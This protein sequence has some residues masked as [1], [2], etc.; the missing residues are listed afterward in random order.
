MSKLLFVGCGKMG[1][2]F[3]RGTVQ[4]ADQIVVIDPAPFPDNIRV[5]ENV[6]WIS[7]FDKIDPLYRP[8]VIVLAIK[9]QHMA[10]VLPLYKGYR[11]SV[12]LSIAAGQ[13]LGRIGE[14]LGSFAQPVVRAMPNL[15]A[16]IGMGTSVAIANGAVSSEQRKVCDTI[17]RSVGDVAW[18]DDEVLIDAV[19]AVSGSGP[20]Y[21]FALV[22]VMAK[23]GEKLGLPAELSLKLARQTVIGSGALLSVAKESASDLREA[24]T[25]PGGT[26]AAALKIL[27]DEK[28][29]PKVMFSAMSA[30][31]KRAKVLSS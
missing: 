13:T 9:P 16:C 14:I 7:S 20:A 30:A 22:E 26:T 4:K 11:D 1:G 2:A 3:L 12:F 29:L 24:V 17:L 28:A 8:D 31:A 19:T 25:S 10:D 5:A 27:L 18:V 6:L 21:V 15:P 23:A